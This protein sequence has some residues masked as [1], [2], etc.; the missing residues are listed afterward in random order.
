MEGRAGAVMRGKVEVVDA[1]GV[2][3]LD[4][5]LRKAQQFDLCQQVPRNARLITMD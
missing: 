2:Y 4:T 3:Q 5:Q 1:A